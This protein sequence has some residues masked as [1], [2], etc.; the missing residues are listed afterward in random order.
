M[1]RM[2]YRK[3]KPGDVYA[4]HDLSPA[5]QNKIRRPGPQTD[6]PF[7]QLG[8]NPLDMYKNFSVMAEFCTSSMRIK[9]RWETGLTNVNQRKLAKAVRRAIGMGLMPAVHT[10]PEIL[11]R[12][13][14]KVNE[15]WARL[16]Y[17][18]T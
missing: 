4:P 13:R 9:P 18:G 12:E 15:R 14:N 7:L 10:H 17:R 8:V 2:Q 6:D 1:E 3:W 5:E 16:E 11:E